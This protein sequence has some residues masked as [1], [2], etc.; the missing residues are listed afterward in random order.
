MTENQ[1]ISFNH[2]WPLFWRK[3][4]G[5]ILEPNKCG[6]SCQPGTIRTEDGS[7]CQDIDE[8]ATGTHKCEQVGQV[9]FSVKKCKFRPVWTLSVHMFVP[10]GMVINKTIRNVTT[11]T[12]ASSMM[13]VL[14]NKSVLTPPVVITVYKPAQLAIGTKFYLSWVLNI[15]SGLDC[16]DINECEEGTHECAQDQICSNLDGSYEC[17]CHD[18]FQR[19]GQ[20][21]VGK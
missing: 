19:I 12:S 14:V 7:S 8:C 9:R 1:L 3:I 2:F 21:C 4:R 13:C 6:V 18:G 5:V 15:F 16:T 17:L 20:K 10:V 11:L